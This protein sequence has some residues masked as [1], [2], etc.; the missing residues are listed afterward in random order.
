MRRFLLI[1]V[2]V[3]VMTG[4]EPHAS[5]DHR[6]NNYCSE[7]GDVCVSTKKRNGVRRLNIGLAAKYFNR[8]RLCVV[9]PDESRECIKRRITD[10]G[11][12]YGDSVNWS[13]HFTDKGEGD[14][15]VIWR[16]GGNRLGKVLG[17]HV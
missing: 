10:Q 17:F 4:L 15:D 6:P 12:S 11:A 14:Y 13:T 5:A 16:Q 7:S 9:A 1:A 3:S 8:Y 2:V